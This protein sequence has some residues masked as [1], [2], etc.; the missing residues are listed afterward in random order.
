MGFHGRAATHKHKITMRNMKCRLEWCKDHQHWN[1]EQW[2]RVLWSDELAV[3]RTNLGL[4]DARRTL[5]DRM[6]SANCKV[7][8]RRNNGL[9]L[10]FMDR[11]RPLRGLLKGNLNATVSNNILDDSVLPTLWQQFG[12]GP[13]LFKHDNA[14][15]HKARSIP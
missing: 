12:E 14:P 10:F 8:W 5:P 15:M 13:F 6:H 7:W 9:G 1:L 4:A 11:A 2:K 3:R